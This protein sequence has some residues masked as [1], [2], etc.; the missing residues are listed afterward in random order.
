MQLEAQENEMMESAISMAIM[1][2]T[3]FVGKYMQFLHCYLLYI[4]SKHHAN[5]TKSSCELHK[6]EI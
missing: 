6:H 5:D 4:T 2:T 1:R 3:I